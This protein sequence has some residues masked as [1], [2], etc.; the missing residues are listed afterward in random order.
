MKLTKLIFS[1]L[2]LCSFALPTVAQDSAP[3]G[4]PVT[5]CV[6]PYGNYPACDTIVVANPTTYQ[7]CGREVSLVSMQPWDG[8]SFRV[9]LMTYNYS[10]LRVMYFLSYVWDAHSSTW[11]VSNFD[12]PSFDDFWFSPGN[13]TACTQLTDAAII[14]RAAPQEVEVVEYVLPSKNH[15]FLTA[16]RDEISFVDAGGAGPWVRTGQTLKMWAGNSF[17]EFK[18]AC[19]FYNHAAVTH[20]YTV[21][22]D[23]CL[24]LV[25][26]N[27]TNDMSKGWVWEAANA[28]LGREPNRAQMTPDGLAVCPNNT[29]A[30][31]RLYNNRFAQND[32]NHRFVNN[33]ATYNEMIAQGWVGE[34]VAFCQR[35]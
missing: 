27:P 2:A 16:Y 21:N 20:F 35:K 22:S 30:V 4:T 15:Y 9:R 6:A 34:G 23:E 32:S 29:T 8:N 26:L 19:R 17:G 10:S 5:S 24:Y 31:L 28:F 12:E 18:N 7:S 25:S 14:A 11:M 3:T 33:V 13:Y 1:A